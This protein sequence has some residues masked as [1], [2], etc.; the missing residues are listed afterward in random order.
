MGVQHSYL[1]H[2]PALVAVGHQPVMLKEVLAHLITTTDGVY[3]DATFGRGGHAAA[4]LSAL[5]FGCGRVIAVDRDAAAASCAQDITRIDSRFRFWPANY[6]RLEQVLETAGE[7]ALDGVLFDLGVSSPQLETPSR[8]FSFLHDGPLDMR[9]GEDA[10]QTAAEWLAVATEAEIADVL[11]RLGE[12][13]ASRKIARMITQQRGRQPLT[14]TRQLAELIVRVVGRRGH[15]HPA[16]RSFQAIRMH[17]NRELEHLQLALRAAV[18]KLR[19]GGRLVVI[20]FH[21]LEDRLVK[22]FIRATATD[23]CVMPPA[24]SLKAITKIKPG[25]A[26]VARN[27]R[28]RSALL[29]VAERRAS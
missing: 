23:S 22:R 17:V 12:E 21:S 10:A 13:R 3:M 18:T 26:E 7:S 11:W 20:S 24:M 16:T 2:E 4:I 14:T 25:T 5:D 19:P 15:K 6:S 1:Q 28:A 27:P 9:M 8:G 29:R